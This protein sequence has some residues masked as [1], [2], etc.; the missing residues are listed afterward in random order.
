MT[1]LTQETSES[2]ASCATDAMTLLTQETSESVASFAIDAMTLLTQETPHLSRKSRRSAPGPGPCSL[3]EGGL[4]GRKKTAGKL[5]SPIT[6]ICREPALTS[7]L[8]GGQLQENQMVLD[9]VGQTRS[10]VQRLHN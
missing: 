3:R 5:L 8:L 1:L 2:V 6:V 7:R 10:G 4:F 9:D